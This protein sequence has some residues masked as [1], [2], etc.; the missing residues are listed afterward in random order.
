MESPQL[1]EEAKHA[2]A[3]AIRQI[4]SPEPRSWESIAA[5]ICLVGSWSMQQPVMTSRLPYLLRQ[6][7]TELILS[8]TLLAFSAGFGWSAARNQQRQGRILGAVVFM[9]SMMMIGSWV[10]YFAGLNGYF[11]RW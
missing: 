7:R 2:I 4:A 6:S 9:L 10:C 5:I 1:T 8:L 11:V 3:G